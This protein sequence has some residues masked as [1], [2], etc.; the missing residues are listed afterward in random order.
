MPLGR[1]WGVESC[2]WSAPRRPESWSRDASRS[3]GVLSQGG[4]PPCLKSL[5]GLCHQMMCAPPDTCIHTRAHTHTATCAQHG[6]Q[7]AP[8]P[9]GEGM[10]RQPRQQAHSRAPNK[11]GGWGGGC[12]QREEWG[13]AAQTGEGCGSKPNRPPAAAASAF[14]HL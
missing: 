12:W 2:P 14:S 1:G 7:K 3:L 5:R 4:N 10:A 6:L 9:A 11:G 8:R 13:R